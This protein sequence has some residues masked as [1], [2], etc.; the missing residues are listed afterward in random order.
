MRHLSTTHWAGIAALAL[1]LW[2]G[3]LR[4]DI[5]I[6][7]AYLELKLDKGRP[8]GEFTISNM[9]DTEERFRVQTTYFSFTEDGAL[10]RLPADDHSMSPWIIFNPKEFSLSAKT[11]QV[12]RFVIAPH[13]TVRP[14]EYWAAMELESLNPRVQH[15]KDDKGHAV[16]INIVS[17]ILVPI[18]GTSGAVNYAGVAR[19]AHLLMKEKTLCLSTTLANTGSG[20]LLVT[21]EYEID[22]P[23]GAAVI[24]GKV[25]KAY[26]FLGAQRTF[27]LPLEKPLPEGDYTLKVSYTCPQLPKP[28]TLV[29]KTSWKP[30]T[31]EK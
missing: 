27:A 30:P 1:V 2:A 10:K 22:N 25:G 29:T 31:E 23:A 6:A 13:Q 3:A 12:V 8:S 20:H 14:G 9:G 11:R 5:A 18:F 7:P 19:D 24:K 21:G 16:A 26:L 4:A 28:I 17:T 15:G